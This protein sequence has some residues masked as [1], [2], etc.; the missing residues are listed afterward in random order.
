M[1]GSAMTA[2]HNHSKIVPFLHRTAEDLS[3]LIGKLD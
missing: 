3:G 1:G 2:G